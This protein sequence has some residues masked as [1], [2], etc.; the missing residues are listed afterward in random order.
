MYSNIDISFLSTRTVPG[1]NRVDATVVP[2]CITDKQ[3][4]SANV[5]GNLN[6]NHGPLVNLFAI[7]VP[8]NLGDRASGYAAAEVDVLSSLQGEYLICRPFDLRSNL[9]YTEQIYEQ[10]ANS[11]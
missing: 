1:F 3:A 6:V 7:L 11:Y 4:A 10:S 8:D 2:V 9:K 5:S